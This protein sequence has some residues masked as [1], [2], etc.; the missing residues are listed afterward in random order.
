MMGWAHLHGACAL[1]T[2]LWGRVDVTGSPGLPTRAELQGWG[3]VTPGWPS[4]W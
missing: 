4:V 3:G 2:H 1:D